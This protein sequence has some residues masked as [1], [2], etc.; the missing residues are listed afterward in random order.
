MVKRVFNEDGACKLKF[1][2]MAADDEPFYQHWYR[3][4]Y[5]GNFS[6]FFQILRTILSPIL[7]SD[8]FSNS[9]FSDF[10]RYS[11]F[12]YISD[13]FH[14]VKSAR[15]RSYSGLHFPT[16][17]LNNSEC[18]HFLCRFHDRWANCGIISTLKFIDLINSYP[19]LLGKVKVFSKLLLMTLIDNLCPLVTFVYLAQ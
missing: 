4:T 13:D 1:F 15:I 16:F 3:C 18:G 14:L 12:S 2:R 17:R 6:N 7:I 10:L 9:E 11:V 5:S 8:L 19:N